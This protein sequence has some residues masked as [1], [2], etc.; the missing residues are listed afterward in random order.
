MSKLFVNCIIVRSVR[1]LDI[2][3]RVDMLR[4]SPV[5]TARSPPLVAPRHLSSSLVDSTMGHRPRQHHQSVSCTATALA[6]HT[7][8]F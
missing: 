5:S 2:V 3:Y 7:S 4:T 8:P 6:A 1:T